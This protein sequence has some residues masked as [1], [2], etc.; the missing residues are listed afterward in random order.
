GVFSPVIKPPSRKSDSMRALLALFS[1]P[2]WKSGAKSTPNAGDASCQ[3]TFC[4]RAKINF[5][6]NF[7]CKNTRG[8]PMRAH[9]RGGKRP[10]THDLV[11][12]PLQQ[13][14]RRE[15]GGRVRI[16]RR[17]FFGFLFARRADDVDAVL[18]IGGRTGKENS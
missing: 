14:E 17:D 7:P 6:A 4:S 15:T 8:L 3:A 11:H 2:P 10:H 13:F 18:P 9:F 1:L 16:A 5:F 12:F